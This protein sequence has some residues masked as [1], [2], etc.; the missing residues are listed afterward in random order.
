MFWSGTP[1]QRVCVPAARQVSTRE[2]EG[3]S[4]L[5][6]HSAV[7]CLNK[8]PDWSLNP[9]KPFK[10][11]W[12]DSVHSAPQLH[13]PPPQRPLHHLLSIKSLGRLPLSAREHLA[14][15]YYPPHLSAH[16]TAARAE[17]RVRPCQCYGL[18]MDQRSLTDTIALKAIRIVFFAR[19]GK[20]E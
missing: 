16:V 12:N 8:L 13:P 20:Y 18:L 10:S 6:I 17:L 5:I 3:S 2:S 11:T 7:S 1:A 14:L 15:T 19:S 4:R 9:L